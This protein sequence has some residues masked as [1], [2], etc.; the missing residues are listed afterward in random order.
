METLRTIRESLAV[1]RILSTYTW[2]KIISLPDGDRFQLNFNTFL[3]CLAMPKNP[4][5][6]ILIIQGGVRHM[7][8]NSY[9][10]RTACCF[11]SGNTRI[12]MLEKLLPAA[13]YKFAHDIA[14]ALTYIKTQFPGPITVI[15]YSMGGI[16]LWS[17]LSLGYDQA[18][19]Y[20]PVCC[21]LDLNRFHKVVESH[22]LFRMIQNKACK[23]YHVDGY[24]ELLEFAGTSLEEVSDFEKNVLVNLNGHTSK[25]HSKTIYIISSDDP[26]TSFQDRY[27]LKSPPFTYYIKGGWHCCLDSIFLSTL[28]ACR[29][30]KSSY[31]GKK[32]RLEE[33]SPN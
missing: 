8:S 3:R 32:I 12:F 26:L 10:I 2:S 33:I 4:I 9:Y 22:P 15:G 5:G 21:P 1:S 24:E 14:S 20:I 18:D 27:L 13:N 19:L 30:I 29:Y 23:C 11:I 28:L 31:Q 7:D 17:Y 25:W 6:N 16:L